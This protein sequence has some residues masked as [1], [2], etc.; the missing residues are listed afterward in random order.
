MA[1]CADQILI[2]IELFFCVVYQ[3]EILISFQLVFDRLRKGYVFVFYVF[4]Y[5][6]KRDKIIEK[7]ISVDHPS[8]KLLSYFQISNQ[9]FI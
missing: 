2:R 5:I 9:A 6:C 1:T 8:N 7:Q 3:D 4:M